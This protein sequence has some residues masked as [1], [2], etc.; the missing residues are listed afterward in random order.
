MEIKAMGCYGLLLYVSRFMKKREVLKFV[1]TF[2]D[3]KGYLVH[4]FG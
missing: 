4:E 1:A 3:W 2:I